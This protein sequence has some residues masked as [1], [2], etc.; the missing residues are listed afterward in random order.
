MRVDR[1]FVGGGGAKSPVWL[2]IHADVLKKPIFLTRATE[3]CALG[4]V[5]AASL[6]ARVYPDFDAA[7]RAMVHLERTVAPNPANAPIYDELFARYTALYHALN[8]SGKTSEL[9]K[10]ID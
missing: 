3:S 9:S 1:V 2:Q 6:A 7:A 10:I 8:R 4:A 5:L